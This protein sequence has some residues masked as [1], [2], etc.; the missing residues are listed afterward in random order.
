MEVPHVIVH[1]FIETVTDVI[2]PE[3]VHVVLA[4]E[5]LKHNK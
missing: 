1:D 4:I 3:H 5:T 2:N